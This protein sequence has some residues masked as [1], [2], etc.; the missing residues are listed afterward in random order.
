MAAVTEA[1]AIDLVPR[2]QERLGGLLKLK[3]KEVRLYPLEPA[4]RTKYACE[5]KAWNTGPKASPV[6]VY[7]NRSLTSEY[8]LPAVVI[9]QG[10][11]YEYTVD[12]DGVVHFATALLESDQVHA[13]FTW[14]LFTEQELQDALALHGVGK[15]DMHLPV[16][17]DPDRVPS[18]LFE[19][20][21]MGAML[22]LYK[23][24]DSEENLYY[25]YSLQDQ[26]HQASQVHG[27]LQKTIDGLNTEFMDAVDSLLWFKYQG[28][29]SKTTSVKLPYRSSDII[30][31]RGINSGYG[32]A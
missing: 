16:T 17:T 12:V 6:V 30:R 8:T 27:N 11:V 25:S 28:R 7:K 26:S 24:I 22:H 18:H 13:S 32:T 19:P 10:S 15:L 20:L 1:K 2:L 31:D 21:V 3:V 23:S 14:R 9:R 4:V 29:A 5:Y